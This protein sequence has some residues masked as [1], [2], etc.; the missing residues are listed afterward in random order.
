MEDDSG[1][2]VVGSSSKGRRRAAAARKSEDSA[3]VGASSGRV[4]T[5]VADTAAFIRSN[6]VRLDSIADEVVTIGEVVAEV[7]D[8]NAR[9]ALALAVAL[10]DIKVR[11]PSDEAIAAVAAFAKKTG[12][13]NVLSKTDLKV[14]ALTWMLEKEKSG[15]AHLRTEPMR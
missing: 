4:G 13:F 3:E 6:G 8:H 5:L 11:I 7:R 12:D 14:L 10:A 2:T 15:T 9:A 1:F